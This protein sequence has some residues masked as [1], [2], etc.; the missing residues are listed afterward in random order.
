MAWKWDAGAAD[1]GRQALNDG[2]RKQAQ[3]DAAELDWWRREFATRFEP[4]S[5]PK[6]GTPLYGHRLRVVTVDGDEI[7]GH[8]K[9]KA[10]QPRMSAADVERVI[11]N[12]W[13]ASAGVLIGVLAASD[14]GFSYAGLA[15]IK[16]AFMQ[17]R[18]E[19]TLDG[20]LRATEQAEK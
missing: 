19:V 10:S 8:G 11:D 2:G 9:V 13:M 5:L 20:I 1:F 6:V 4:D 12:V 16:A 18:D 7:D 14:K 3:R 15:R 17:G